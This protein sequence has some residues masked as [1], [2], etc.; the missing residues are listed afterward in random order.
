MRHGRGFPLSPSVTLALGTLLFAVHG[1][2]AP[3]ETYTPARE[4]AACHKTIH[5]Y[6]SESAHAQAVGPTYR[7]ALEAA[8]AASSDKDGVRQTCVSCHAPAAH[9]TGD[10]ALQGPLAKEA[11]T[12]DFCHTVTAVDLGKTGR[13]FQTEP[14]RRKLG[15]LQF[16]KSPFHDTVYSPLHKA[17][18]LLCAGCH[19][20]KNARGVAVLSNYS[21]WKESAYPARGMLCQ[22][23]HMPVVPG[24]TVREGLASDQRQINLHRMVGGSGY[25]QIR[26]GLDLEIAS[27][28]LGA[29]SAEVDV[30]VTNSGVGHAAPGGL[31]TK[32]I[33]LAVGV[34]S[35]SGE[36]QHARERVYHRTLLDGDGRTLATVPDLFLRAASIGEDTRLKP[37]EARTE[38]FTVPLPEGAKAIVAR[39]EYRDASDPKGTKATPVTEERRDL[40]GR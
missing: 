2:G 10:Y 6:W 1:E 37:G 29:A 12:C 30:V 20:Y 31:S 7:D 33:V 5:T 4:C 23:C 38:H 28:S 15:P 34:A 25:A 19:E 26:R 36:L 40:A 8:V 9:A 35:G 39:L 11:V 16:A 18:A 22:E 13:P 14:G 27:V 17:S 3:A 32:A 21:E 24:A